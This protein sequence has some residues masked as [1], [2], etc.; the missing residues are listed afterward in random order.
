MVDVTE[1]AAAM[2][3]AGRLFADA[4]LKDRPGC[5]GSGDK[6]IIW[7]GGM[8]MVTIAVGLI[9]GVAS[10]FGTAGGVHAQSSVPSVAMVKQALKL[11]KTQWIQFRNYNGRQLVYFTLFVTYKCGLKEI[12]Y[13]VNSADLGKQFPLPECVPLVPYNV[14]PTDK[15]YLT[16][17]PGTAKTVS[18]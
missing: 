16:F 6:R 17:G 10:L 13:S 7:E 3:R 12:R 2:A 15:V 14:G 9:A 1:K 18:V 4:G 5:N 8:R 11:S